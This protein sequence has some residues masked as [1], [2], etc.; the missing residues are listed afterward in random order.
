[1]VVLHDLVNIERHLVVLQAQMSV[2]RN[3]VQ[4][5]PRWVR[6]DVGEARGRPG[7]HVVENALVAPVRN[8]CEAGLDGSAEA[9]RVIE[10]M[11]RHDQVRQRLTRDEPVGEVDYR[12]CLFRG[13]TEL[14]YH[15]VIRKLDERVTSR[16]QVPEPIGDL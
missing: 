3:K 15:E 11:M 12:A 1:V 13:P 6:H 7:R 10:M 14:E 16:I 5:P 2:N 4:C 9:P 8:Y